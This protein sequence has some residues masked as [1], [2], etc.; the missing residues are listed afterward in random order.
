MRQVLG[1]NSLRENARHPVSEIGVSRLRENGQ[2]AYFERFCAQCEEECVTVMTLRRLDSD[3]FRGLL[4]RLYIIGHSYVSS[5]QK[6]NSFLSS[7][8]VSSILFFFFFFGIRFILC[9]K[10]RPKYSLDM[11]T[12]YLNKYWTFTLYPAGPQ[13]GILRPKCCFPGPC[14]LLAPNTSP[15]TDSRYQLLHFYLCPAG[16]LV[17]SLRG[18]D[19][20]P[21]CCIGGFGIKT[22]RSPDVFL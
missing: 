21:P 10:A 7:S 14:T 5:K 8:L 1:R 13:R 20:R 2:R 16:I 11:L 18:N 17:A 4:G 15:P 22:C 3:Q 19:Q 6:P 9:D 12:N